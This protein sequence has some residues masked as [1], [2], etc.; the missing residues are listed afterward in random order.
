MDRI[1]SL[2]VT[3]CSSI[4]ISILIDDNGTNP[5]AGLNYSL[6]CEVSGVNSNAS[7]G[8]DVS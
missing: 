1:A 3:A 6:Y 5:V 8:V 7:A 4:D 2:V